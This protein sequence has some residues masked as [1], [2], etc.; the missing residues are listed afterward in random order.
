M[1]GSS[2]RKQNRHYEWVNE[3][4]LVQSRTKP[5]L[6]SVSKEK[7][8]T[9]LLILSIPADL[10]L[11]IIGAILTRETVIGGRKWKP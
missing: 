8:M 1:S 5:L 6:E 9:L 7:Y 4:I 3:S 10:T 11:L 2:R